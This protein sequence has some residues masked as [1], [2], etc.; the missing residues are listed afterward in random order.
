MHFTFFVG[1]KGTCLEYE[2]SKFHFIL[3]GIS[4]GIKITSCILLIIFSMYIHKT[5]ILKRR[6]R[7]KVILNHDITSVLTP[8]QKYRIDSVVASTD[9]L[10]NYENNQI[11]SG[12]PTKNITKKSSSVILRRHQSFTD[13]DRAQ[14]PDNFSSKNVS[15][16]EIGSSSLISND[17]MTSNSNRKQSSK[18]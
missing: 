15:L 3:F 11:K 4:A 16:K 6:F 13:L 10:R 1:D 9:S 5:F 18:F 8:K 12:N 17:L 14:T 7:D 2:T